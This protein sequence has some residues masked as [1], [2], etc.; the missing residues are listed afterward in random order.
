MLSNRRAAWRLAA[1]AA[2]FVADNCLAAEPGQTP[3]HEL[4][5]AYIKYQSTFWQGPGYVGIPCRSL[6]EGDRNLVYGDLNADGR[7]DAVFV[8]TQDDGEA[9]YVAAVVN[10]QNPPRAVNSSQHRGRIRRVD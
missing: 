3:T 10:R 5:L 7:E 9:I 6:V 4:S 1:L 2:T 8:C